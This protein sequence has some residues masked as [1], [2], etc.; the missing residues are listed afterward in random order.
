MGDFLRPRLESVLLALLPLTVAATV[1]LRQARPFSV[2]SDDHS[3]YGIATSA[4]RAT[5]DGLAEGPAIAVREFFR[6]CSVSGQLPPHISRKRPLLLWVWSAAYLAGGNLGLVWAWRVLY[7]LTMVLLYLVLRIHCSPRIAAAAAA[8]VAAAPAV[9]GLLAWMSCST[10]LVSYSLLL[11]GIWILRSRRGNAATVA[12]VA[13]LVLSLLS[14][15]VMFLLVPTAVAVD[16]WISGRR[17]LACAMPFLAAS[18]WLLLP[19]ED[20]SVLGSLLTDPWLVVRSS[21]TVIMGHA[22]SLVRNTGLLLTGAT[23]VFVS[24]RRI[25]PLAF[26]AAALVAPGAA[27]V[28]P[29]VLLAS[30]RG[31]KSLPGVV[32]AAV[33]TLSLC[34]YGTFTSRYAMEPLLGCVLA[35]APAF[36]CPLRRSHGIALIALVAWHLL[37]CLAPDLAYRWPPLRSAA[38]IADKRFE[39]LALVNAL[40]ENEWV[41]FASRAR[42]PWEVMP[43]W[44]VLSRD[45]TPEDRVSSSG[46]YLRLGY[47]LN[48]HCPQIDDVIISR[49]RMW[50][51]NVWYWRVIPPRKGAGIH[52]QGPEPWCVHAEPSPVTHDRCRQVVPSPAPAP[53]VMRRH[54]F[55]QWCADTPELMN[56]QRVRCWLTEVWDSEEG[57][58]DDRWRSSFRELELGRLLIRDDGWLDA[59]ELAYLRR[60]TRRGTGR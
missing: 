15:E 30:C 7:V 12:G 19:G 26:V 42:T 16:L 9:Q 21:V 60:Y 50:E 31:A 17:R 6:A 32:W 8:T 2:V 58:P 22:A 25:M 27:I 20:R 10:Y 36:P 28:I 43:E 49:T 45:G 47:G 23:A 4:A 54:A 11:L 55:D 39:S 46:P 3:Y 48:L 51:W 37:V 41:S 40:R 38:T 18:A 29:I 56:P 53:I 57:C 24:R 1:V 34:L 13:A 44:S 14:R 52:V 33:A 5:R 59:S 35:V